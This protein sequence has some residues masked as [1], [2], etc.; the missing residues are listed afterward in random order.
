MK[1][2]YENIKLISEQIQC[3]KY[4]IGEFVG[5]YTLLL[6][7][8]ACSLATQSFVV[9]RVIEVVGKESVITSTN[10]GLN[11]NRLFQDKMLW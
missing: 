3:E 8:L 5:I 9:F 1:E 6:Y 7:F 4:I 11:E 10:S 2:T